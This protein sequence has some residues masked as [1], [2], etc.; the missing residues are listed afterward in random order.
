MRRVGQ[1]GASGYLAAMAL[2]GVAPT[3]MKP[4]ALVAGAGGVLGATL[5]SRLLPAAILPRLL[6]AVLLVAGVR[7][8]VI[9]WA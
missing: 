3:V 7:L 1:A 6:P 8:L 2:M 9:Q 5:G 4:T